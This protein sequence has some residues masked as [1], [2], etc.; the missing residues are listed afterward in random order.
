MSDERVCEC[1]NPNRN[2]FIWRGDPDWW[3]CL[4][5]DGRVRPLTESEKS[6]RE[7]ARCHTETR[8]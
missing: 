8:R 3:S 7:H 5:C 1:E 2:M 6:N 4:Q